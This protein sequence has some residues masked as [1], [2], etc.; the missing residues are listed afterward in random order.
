MPEC[1]EQ[2]VIE[3]LRHGEYLQ[4]SKENIVSFFHAEP[5]DEKKAEYLKTIFPKET[6]CGFYRKGTKEYIGYRTYDKY[7]DLID[8]SGLNPRARTELPWLM[9]AK[10]MDALI[11][12]GQYLD[13][14][15]KPIIA[16]TPKK[17]YPQFDI[18]QE[19]IDN[20]LRLGG[21][22]KNS[23]QRIYS[24]Y[25]RCDDVQSRISFLKK[26]YES[27]SVGIMVGDRKAAAKWDENGV[28]FRV[29]LMEHIDKGSQCFKGIAFPMVLIG[30]CVSQADRAIFGHDHDFAHHLVGFLQ[31]N[32][33][34]GGS[35]H[36]HHI[37]LTALHQGHDAIIV[38][39]LSSLIP[40]ADLVVAIV[41]HN[42]RI[43][44]CNIAENQTVGFHKNHILFSLS[45]TETLS[46]PPKILGNLLP[47]SRM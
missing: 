7:L 20:F 35:I 9:I 25:R 4:Q 38:L 29:L 22:V 40:G 17:S 2:T 26:E 37:I 18:S 36:G 33:C 15:P 34:H 42:F 45:T 1:D 23:T 30:E 16:E 27:D 24:F 28:S 44:R 5:D 10:M 8:G 43:L 32:S 47:T 31:R 11:R 12:T 39:S 6:Y 41:V 3:I 19:I 21:C 46:I 13:E 14:K